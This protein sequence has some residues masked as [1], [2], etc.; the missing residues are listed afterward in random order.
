MSKLYI[1]SDTFFI[2][3]SEKQW[4]KL[5]EHPLSK[6]HN[7]PQE[8]RETKNRST[9]FGFYITL[10][11]LLDDLNIILN[12]ILVVVAPT[13]FHCIR[14]I[15]YL[16]EQVKHKPWIPVCCVTCRPFKPSVLWTG[17]GGDLAVFPQGCNLSQL[18]REGLLV[19]TRPLLYEALAM[20]IW[21]DRCCSLKKHHLRAEIKT[22]WFSVL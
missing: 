22:R 20:L 14:A 17:T 8:G 9:V 6:S 2:F 15:L 4:K 12:F 16:N 3:S 5:H 18:I 11:S 1:F 19:H 10:H 21:A 13:V 7:G